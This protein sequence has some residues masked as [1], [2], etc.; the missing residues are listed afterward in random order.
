MS[1][2]HERTIFSVD[3][4]KHGDL[5]VTGAADNAI[6]VFQGQPTD[7]PSSFE[8]AVQQKEAH[9]SDINCVRWSPQLQE[10]GGKKALLLAS[11]SDD[12]LVRIWKLQLP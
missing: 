8:L 5:L 3:W 6:R 9:A 4:S 10:D 7:S 11:A 2:C 1:G 12:G